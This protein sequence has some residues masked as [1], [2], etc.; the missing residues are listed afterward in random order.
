MDCNLSATLQSLRNSVVVIGY[1]NELR[2]DDGVGQKIA[3]QVEHWGVPNVRSLAVHQLTPEIA[4]TIADANTVIFV[5][6]YPATD[7][8]ATVQVISIEP[9]DSPDSSIGH[10][11]DPRSLLAFTEHLYDRTPHAWVIAIPAFNFDFG[12]SLSP[13]TEKNMEDALEEI[14][15][16]IRTPQVSDKN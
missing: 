10:S 1:G 4:E 12:E 3:N 7:E 11:S 14:D 15:Y 2:S 13:L 16:L 8:N 5:D 6:A 9:A